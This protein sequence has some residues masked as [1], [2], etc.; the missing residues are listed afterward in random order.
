[1]H[2]MSKEYSGLEFINEFGS[3]SSDDY[4]FID[5]YFPKF[6]NRYFSGINN[7]AFENG[8]KQIINNNII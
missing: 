2:S 4:K 3:S 7:E 1:M 5:K 8:I 6:M